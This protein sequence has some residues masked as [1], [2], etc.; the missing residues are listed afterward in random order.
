MLPNSQETAD[1]VSFTEEILNG[2]LHFLCSVSL[3][4]NYNNYKGYQSTVLSCY[5]GARYCFMLLDTG[6][7]DNNKDSGA[8]VNSGAVELAGE[9][10]LDVPPPSAFNTAQKI[11]FPLGIPSVNLTKSTASF[12]FT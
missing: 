11:N 3:I 5:R 6:Q 8:L 2:K 4:S 9:N 12:R 10:K 1:L 7:F